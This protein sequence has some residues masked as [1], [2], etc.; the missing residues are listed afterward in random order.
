MSVPV[1]KPSIK[2]KEMDSVL[3]CLV[4][5]Q[6]GHGSVSVETAEVLMERTGTVACHFFREYERAIE[7]AFSMMDAEEGDQFILSPLVPGAYLHILKKMKLEPIFVDVES[8][9]AAVD[10]DD[11]LDR[12]TEKTRGILLYGP[13]GYQWDFTEWDLSGITLFEDVTQNF[14][15]EV[16][17]IKSG[18]MGDI[19]IMRME[20]ED[21]ITCG[22]GSA[23]MVRDKDMK[24]FLKEIVGR[25]DKSILLSDINAALALVQIKDFEKNFEL[26]RELH[27]LFLTSLMKSRHGYL[28]GHSENIA[29]YSSLPVLVKGKVKEIQGYALK[30]NVETTL[31]FKGCCL[32]VGQDYEIHCPEAETLVLNC[33]LF[34]LYPSLGKQNCELIT[35]ILA[36]LP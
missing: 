17:E 6:I 31:A 18:F 22:G 34:P 14:G 4:S 33:V 16:K 32:E 8:H 24:S 21:L 25:Y 23:L 3:T 26:R 20:A 29:Y 15:S 30:K 2:R 19:V 11:I 1:Y 5:D 13:F 7:I 36:T 27:E 28:T 12:I 10:L 35:R 9:T